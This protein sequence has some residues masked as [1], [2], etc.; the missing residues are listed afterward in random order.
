[1]PS[2]RQGTSWAVGLDGIDEIKPMIERIHFVEPEI[3]DNRLGIIVHNIARIHVDKLG[4][5]HF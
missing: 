4:E 5:I 1:M 2:I 3:R